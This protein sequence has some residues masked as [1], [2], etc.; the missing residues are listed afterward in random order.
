M[1]PAIASYMKSLRAAAD[2]A[3]R[4]LCRSPW[5]LRDFVAQRSWMF[6]AEERACL[7][8]LFAAHSDASVGYSIEQERRASAGNVAD[9]QRISKIGPARAAGG[10]RALLFPAYMRRSRLN[11]ASR[12]N[13]RPASPMASMSTGVTHG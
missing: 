6:D 2:V 3:Q 13:R 8:A 1:N 9:P 11:R 4:P 10:L 5:A 7:H 12:A